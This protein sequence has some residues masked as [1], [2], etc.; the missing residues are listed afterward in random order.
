MPYNTVNPQT[1]YQARPELQTELKRAHD[2]LH[3]QLGPYVNHTV[4]VQTVDHHVHEGRIVHIDRDH[5]Y[6]SVPHPYHA[7]AP[8]THG[9]MPRSASF[10]YL[11]KRRSA[12]GAVQ[13][14][15]GDTAELTLDPFRPKT[16]KPPPS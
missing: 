7:P 9:T 1:L 5:L 12:A 15:G 8:G 13:S 10:L 16:K 11:Q 2:H 6:L 4:R 3:H 14:A